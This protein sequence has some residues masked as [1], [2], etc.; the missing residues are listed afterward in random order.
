M[1]TATWIT[2]AGLAALMLVG[3]IRADDDDDGHKKYF[4]RLKEQQK[5]EAEFYR[6]QQKRYD[7]FV[8][9][10]QKWQEEFLREQAK[11]DA[12]FFRERFKD[13]DGWYPPYPERRG[14]E[15]PR[16]AY[17]PEPY[18]GRPERRFEP[19]DSFRFRDYPRYVPRRDDDDD[20]D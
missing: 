13:R 2:A 8:R 3:P 14:Y 1:R 12:E 17:P 15:Y 11:R 20:D 5:R 6:E 4:K 10:K 9:E 7:K 19:V 18:H 16:Y